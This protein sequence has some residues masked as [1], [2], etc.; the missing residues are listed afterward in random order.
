MFFIPKFYT[1]EPKNEK[2]HIIGII[3]WY[4][5]FLL[6]IPLFIVK[7]YNIDNL[8]YYLPVLD[9]IANI[10]SV[11]STKQI[12]IFKDL[13]SLSPNNIISFLS[14]NFINLLALVGVS[15][16][17]IHIAIKRKNVK[18]GIIVT[19]IMYTFTYLLPT[20]GIRQPTAAS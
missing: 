3:V 2:I 14:T 8:R 12:Q 5:V 13:Y 20:Q 10:F 4:I 11:S 9:L 17:G 16:N 7:K 15:W 18:I 1:N 6:I 19:L